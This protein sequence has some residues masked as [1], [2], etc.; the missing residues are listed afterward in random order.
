MIPAMVFSILKFELDFVAGSNEGQHEAEEADG[1]DDVK[2]IEHANW[3]MS[4]V[5]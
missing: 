5:F 1:R 2:Y 3:L 4:C